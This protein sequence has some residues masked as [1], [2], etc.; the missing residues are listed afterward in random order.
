MNSRESA[1]AA[2]VRPFSE[3][4]QFSTDPSAAAV[5]PIEYCLEKRVVVLG[6]PADAVSVTIGM[7][8]PLDQPLLDELAAKLGRPVTPIQLNEFEIRRAISRVFDVP[9]S[10]DPGEVVAL[11]SSRDIVFDTGRP[12]VA[13]LDDLLAAAIRARATDVHIE[14]YHG[15]VD[16]RFRIDGVLRQ[17][18]TPLSPDNLTRVVSR[19]KVLC[20]LDLAEHRRAQDGRFSALYTEDRRSRRI[21]LRVVVLPGPHGQDLSIRVLDPVR[22]ITDLGALSMSPALLARWQ[23]LI[24]RPHGLLITTGPT[25]S[26]KTTTLYSSIAALASDNLKIVSV[27]DPIEYE[28]PKVNQKHVTGQ[29]T[30]ADYLRAFLRSNPDIILVGEVRDSET[31]EFAVRAGTTGHLILSSLHTSDAIA[32]IG[33]LRV[34]GIPDDHLS[35]VL[36]GVL[37]QRLLRRVCDSCREEVEPDRALLRRFTDRKL[38]GRF[39]R[40]KGCERCAGTGYFGLVGVYELFEPDLELA[41]AIASGEPVGRL[42]R[43]AAGHGWAPLVDDALGKAAA[44]LTTIEEIA[45]RIPP[46]AAQGSR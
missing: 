4:P 29:M 18:T 12:A 41:D 31:A 16:L 38:G 23:D 15:D 43:R 22:F 13:M 8:A 10:E 7:L 30:F 26:G 39:A 28:F 2:P 42:R 20:N 33:R 5:L 32:A 25:S 17:V 34:L 1:V 45:R 24:R 6:K 44:G 46:R 40:G 27:E 19:A 36:I 11:E 14:S 3:L 9:V 37:G 35:D 21:D